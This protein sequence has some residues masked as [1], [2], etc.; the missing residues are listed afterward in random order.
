MKPLKRTGIGSFFIECERILNF[1]LLLQVKDKLKSVGISGFQANS[2]LNS[3]SYAS[4]RN[5]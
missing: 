2:L 5:K 3:V 4:E 1:H